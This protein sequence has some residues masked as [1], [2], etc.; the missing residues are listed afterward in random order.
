MAEMPERFIQPSLKFCY[1]WDT[2]EY[3]TKY[4]KIY[5]NLYQVI[6]TNLFSK[7]KYYVVKETEENCKRR[8]L[9]VLT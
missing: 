7:P 8:R 2:M 5:M 1:I 4:I 3:Q 9:H 6:V